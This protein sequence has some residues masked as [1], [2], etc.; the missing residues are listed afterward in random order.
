[1]ALSERR[2]LKSV[3]ILSESKSAQVQWADQVLRDDV[4]IHEQ[5]HR[6]AY[7]EADKEKFLAEVDGAKAYIK[8]LGW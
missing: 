3:Q 8:I 5:Y 7:S 1:M 4:V 6:C 2:I